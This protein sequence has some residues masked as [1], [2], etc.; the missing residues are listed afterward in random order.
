[1]ISLAVN[2]GR[3]FAA[4]S[5]ELVLKFRKCYL[6]EKNKYAMRDARGSYQL[7][8]E[9]A[10]SASLALLII[11]FL[12][13]PRLNIKIRKFDKVYF[14]PTIESVPITRQGGSPTPPK[15]PAVPVP[16]DDPAV[17]LDET[18]DT[19]EL[20]YN[21]YQYNP[22]G[23]GG[24][25]GGQ[26]RI[27]P[28]RPVAEV[29]PEYPKEARKKGLQGFV[30]LNLFIDEHGNVTE[31]V[32]VT[33]STGSED[34]AKEAVKAARASRFLPAQQGGKAV[35]TWTVREYGFYF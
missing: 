2:L 18:I 29:F 7:R 30:K 19:T 20:N 13:F 9:K 31:V 17:P 22:D 12:L 6:T 26:P 1:M 32:I 21:V 3:V 8:F 25:A 35:G 5:T 23:L 27:I 10:L 15:R 14:I 34:C 24:P 4:I 16:V 28:P 33:N 11:L